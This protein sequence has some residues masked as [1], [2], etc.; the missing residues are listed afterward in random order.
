MT[1]PLLKNHVMRGQES[2]LRTRGSKPRI[3]TSRNYPAPSVSLENRREI[4]SVYFL[5]SLIYS[6]CSEAAVGLGGFEPPPGRLK[7]CCATVTPRPRMRTWP[8]L[9]DLS[10]SMFFSLL[11]R[12]KFLSFLTLKKEVIISSS[13][14]QSLKPTI[15]G[16][17]KPP[18]RK[19]VN[20]LGWS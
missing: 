9:S 13:G 6:L 8:R 18:L 15:R 14:F 19:T 7:I 10:C 3:S 12:L 5:L 17:W 2:N 1:L 20:R 11:N 16:G 4:P